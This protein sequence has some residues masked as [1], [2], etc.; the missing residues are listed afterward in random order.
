MN[1]HGTE[2]VNQT[3]IDSTSIYTIAKVLNVSENEI[4]DIQILKKGMTNRSFSFI[5]K[6]EK[7]IIRIPGEGTNQLINRANEARVYHTIKGKGICDDPVYINPKD[8]F[9]ITRYIENVRVCDSMN[10]DDLIVC[11]KKLKEFHNMN[12]KANHVFDIFGQLQYYEELW[13]GTPSIYSDYEETKENVMH[14][15]SYIEE[16]RNKWCLTHIDA[17]PDNF[18]FYN[19]G[20]QLTDWEYAGM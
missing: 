12:L 20:V 16:H 18:L 11:M 9:K 13:E 8:G 7:Y 2:K 6:S 4:S 1:A 10:Q 17:V 15:K 19:E 14:L 3:F 5:C